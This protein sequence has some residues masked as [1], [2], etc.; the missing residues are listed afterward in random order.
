M[1]VFD[2]PNL[3]SCP[4][5]APVLQLAERSGLPEL[6]ARHVSIGRPGG[7][8]ADLKVPALVA[9]MVAGA[10]SIDDMGPATRHDQPPHRQQR[11]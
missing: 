11:H 4:G 10:D 9:G 8:N 5:L 2:D 7:A 3:V 6:V 1:A